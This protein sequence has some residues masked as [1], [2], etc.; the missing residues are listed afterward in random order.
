MK[1]ITLLFLVF[2]ISSLGYSQEINSKKGAVLRTNS[3]QNKNFLQA[4]RSMTTDDCG[5]ETLGN[6]FETSLGSLKNYIIAND[7]VVDEEMGVFS[8][9]A[10]TFHAFVE[11]GGDIDDVDYFF[12]EDSADGPGNLITSLENV[13]STSVEVAGEYEDDDGL[14]DVLEVY[15]ELDE[16]LTFESEEG[17]AVYWMGVQVPNYGGSSISF[18]LISELDT[19]NETFVFLGGGWNGIQ[20]LF[21]VTRDGVMTLSGTCLAA[22]EC[23]EVSAGSLE[24]PESVCAL[25]EFMISP[26][27]A[28]IGVSG[29]VY[30]WEQS[31]IDEENWTVIEDAT[32]LN[33]TMEEGITA[34]TQFRF[35]IE[36]EF[37]NTDT[38]EP[39]EVN[40]NSAEECY[41]DPE[42]SLGCSDGDVIN[43]VII[44]DEAGEVIFQNDSDC[45]ETGYT[46]YTQDL[47][48]PELMLGDTYTMNIT[49]ESEL[50]DEEDVR[51]WLDFNQDGVFADNEEIGNTVGEGLDEDGEFN[52][53]FTIPEELE[54][55]TYRIR[56][57]MAWLGGDD[58]EPCVNKSYGEAEDYAVEIIDEMGVEDSVF[59]Q[60]SFYPNPVENQLNLRAGTPIENLRVYNMLGQEVLKESPN[61]SETQLQ[62]EAL[63]TGIY[64]I[65]V[66]LQGVQKSYKIIK[67]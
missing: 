13:E 63:P 34:P 56:V 17:G 1:K 25:S 42:Y 57:R 53:Q 29:V 19:P 66:T 18:E 3:Q 26:V 24:G 23:S 6:D 65:N 59:N 37:G 50:T 4:P 61:T 20:S 30:T 46:D 49:S 22:E 48:A 41:C 55:G 36:C 64:W 39:F 45:S 35:I 10:I 51:I 2:L 58:I 15:V 28:T 5:Q 12:Y 21:G 14:K 32:S 33:L 67:K 9:E 40:L 54:L 11:P 43:Q 7:F 31:P 38:S 47:Q 16:P 60:F 27:D 52:F 8:L 44:E 62:T